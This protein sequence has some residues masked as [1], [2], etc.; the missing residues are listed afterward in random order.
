MMKYN[1]AIA[2]LERIADNV[3]LYSNL[4][5]IFFDH[6]TD[7]QT[8]NIKERFRYKM[9]LLP[10]YRRVPLFQKISSAIVNYLSRTMTITMYRGYSRGLHLYLA[11]EQACSRVEYLI[12]VIL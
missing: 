5:M 3:A 6:F 11:G 7:E 4:F 12:N 8:V 2:D 10:H 9:V 1:D